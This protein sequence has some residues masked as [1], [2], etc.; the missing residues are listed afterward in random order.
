MKKYAVFVVDENGKRSDLSKSQLTELQ[1]RKVT[2]ASIKSEEQIRREDQQADK[3]FKQLKKN[4]AAYLR[5]NE[6]EKVTD[7]LK[8]KLIQN[9]KAPKGSTKDQL[10]E[11]FIKGH[12][13]RYLERERV[14]KAEQAKAA[15][16]AK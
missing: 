12:E 8:R 4:Y 13:Q 14:Q 16:Q 6:Y 7:V 10:H 11:Q 15:K 5:E 1:P 2:G 3:E 9:K